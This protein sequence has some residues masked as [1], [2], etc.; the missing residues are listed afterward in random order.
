MALPLPPAVQEMFEIIVPAPTQIIKLKPTRTQPLLNLAGSS[1]TTVQDFVG[2]LQFAAIRSERRYLVLFGK[3]AKGDSPRKSWN[4]LSFVLLNVG[5][6][7]IARY[8]SSRFGLDLVDF[9]PLAYVHTAFLAIARTGAFSYLHSLLD[10]GL[11]FGP[12]K[13]GFNAIFPAA[14]RA[15]W[16]TN[17]I[18]STPLTPADIERQIGPLK[19]TTFLA[20]ASSVQSGTLLYIPNA[21]LKIT[22]MLSRSLLSV[23]LRLFFGPLSHTFDTVFPAAARSVLASILTMIAST[24]RLPAIVK[25]LLSPFEYR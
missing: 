12:L 25:Y 16:Y 20:G 5:I 4:V 7:S 22:S 17:P 18:T 14:A 3:P 10:V 8:A 13:H 9:D 19:R 24:L 15:Q 6:I 2:P 1:C 23:D 21:L 11:L